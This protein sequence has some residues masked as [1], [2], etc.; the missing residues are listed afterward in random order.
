VKI[1]LVQKLWSTCYITTHQAVPGS[2]AGEL[3]LPEI[4]TVTSW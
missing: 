1:V 4:V 3:P 2:L